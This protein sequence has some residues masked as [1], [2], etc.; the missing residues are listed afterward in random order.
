F[1]LPFV[2]FTG[3]SRLLT[4]IG[5][6]TLVL[7]LVWLGLVLLRTRGHLS[8]VLSRVD[9]VGALLLALALA[10]V[11]LAFATADPERQLM[12]SAGPWLLAAAAV[13]AVAFA[14]WQRRTS[15]AIV[16]RG[17]LGSSAAWGSL[18]VSF[19]IG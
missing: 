12:S 19:L 8:D 11:V 7:A 14:L 10:G 16:S 4:P 3:T 9:L 18:L 15:A 2:P 1:G 17:L 13:C 5:V 6:A